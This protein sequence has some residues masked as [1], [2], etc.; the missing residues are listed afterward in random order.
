MDIG[1]DSPI[2]HDSFDIIK[3]VKSQGINNFIVYQAIKIYMNISDSLD[4]Y[5]DF[6][7]V[8]L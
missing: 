5:A 1:A 7:R 6:A 3:L 4:Q 8:E 2:Q